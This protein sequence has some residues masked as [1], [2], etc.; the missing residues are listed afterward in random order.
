MND[1]IAILVQF[2]LNFILSLT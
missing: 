2:I 1:I